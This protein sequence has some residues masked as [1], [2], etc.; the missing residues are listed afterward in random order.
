VSTRA[1][2]IAPRR[3]GTGRPASRIDW[4]RLGRVSLVVILFVI[5]ILYINPV[6][7]FVDAWRDSG[8]EKAQLAE[9]K[10]E[11]QELKARAETLQH[12]DAAELGARSLG[13][14]QPDERSVVI[15]DSD[16]PEACGVETP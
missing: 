4:E 2:R 12:S 15:C 13:M 9:L 8:A 11:N 6:V 14:V 5:L 16:G 1:Y 7:N 10:A 3:P